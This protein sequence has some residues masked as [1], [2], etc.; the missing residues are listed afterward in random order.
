MHDLRCSA[1]GP[2][3]YK[4]PAENEIDCNNVCQTT[5]EYECNSLLSLVLHVWLRCE[6]VFFS[7]IVH[8]VGHMVVQ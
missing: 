3:Q 2:L 6:N 1:V 7:R 4:M 8:Q 5:N